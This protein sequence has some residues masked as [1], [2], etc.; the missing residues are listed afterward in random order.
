MAADGSNQVRLTD[1]KTDDITPAWSNDGKQIAWSRAR[2]IW[3]MNADGSGKTQV[4]FNTFGDFRPTWSPDGSR[5]AFRSTRSFAPGIYVIN[6][7][8][9]G[10]QWLSNDLSTTNFAPDWSPDGTKIAFTRQNGV[11]SGHF[12]IWVMN[13]DGTNPHQL[14]P[15]SMEAALPGWSPDG[16]RILFADAY[17]T[18]CGE[19][20]L[21]A[22][23]ADGNGITQITDT[24][25][26]ELAK[27]WSRDSRRIV[28]ELGIVTPSDQ[29]LSK[30]DIAV[31]D[32]ATGATVNLTNSA[33]V[34]EADPD[35][36][37]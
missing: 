14:T 25:E 15:D 16:T 18:T 31:I 9:T 36:A 13:A 33:G 4:T 22:M 8:G 28:A 24:A 23:N 5:I 29:H 30:G 34:S 26:N 6:V 32:L 21:F 11:F 12:A 2:E 1:D 27:S 37:P 3:A 20:D 10:E 35:W 7:D 19:S 17:C